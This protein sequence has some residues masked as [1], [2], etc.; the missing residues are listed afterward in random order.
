VNFIQ[1]PALEE[2]DEAGRAT[3]HK[4]VGARVVTTFR[5]AS[6]VTL[7]SG[8]VLLVTTGYLFDRWVFASAVY[9]PPLKGLLLWSGTAAAVV[10]WVLV[11][12]V[13]WPAVRVVQSGADADAKAAARGRVR[14]CARINLFLAVPVTFVMVA[15]A[16]L[17]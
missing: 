4:L 5:R 2:A 15:A 6:H 9:V 7:A 3:I 16:H 1:L 17:Y 12:M 14:L 10:M 8:A 13:I 11:H